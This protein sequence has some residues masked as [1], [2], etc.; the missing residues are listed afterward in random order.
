VIEVHLD[1]TGFPVTLR[2]TAGLREVADPVEQEGVRRAWDAV[3]DADLVL[4]VMESAAIEAGLSLLQR[5]PADRQHWMILN[6]A[7]LLTPA[8]GQD[9]LSKL[10][11]QLPDQTLLIISAMNGAG[12]EGLVAA[13]AEFAERFFTAAPAL[14]TRERHRMALRE[15]SGALEGALRLGPQGEEELIAE[16]IRLA[17]RALER[18]TG[19]IGVEDILDKIFR[20]FCIGK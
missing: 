2:D 10:A 8:A 1:L 16:H 12:I 6:K 20:D 5:R 4:W 19:R 7:D 9:L 14:V 11:Q 18:L 3:T 15:A 17:A 13:L